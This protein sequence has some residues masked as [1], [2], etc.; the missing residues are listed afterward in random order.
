MLW[1]LGAVC[2]KVASVS[3]LERIVEVLVLAVAEEAL[4][5]LLD[6]FEVERPPEEFPLVGSGLLRV[7]IS[8]R[9][10]PE[11]PALVGLQTYCPNRTRQSSS[12]LFRITFLF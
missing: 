8:T 9:P 11:L 3:D 4:D 6:L 7:D 12:S 5:P 1:P 2:L 10:L